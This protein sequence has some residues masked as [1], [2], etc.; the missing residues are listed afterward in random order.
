MPAPEPNVTSAPI[1]IVGPSR[2][3][4][5]M[6]REVFNR[7]PDVWITRETHYFDDLR[8]RRSASRDEIEDYFLRIGTR[9]YGAAFSA[10][11][12]DE[13]DRLRLRAAAAQLGTGRDAYFEAF[14]RL[15][16]AREG[17]A[18]WGEKTPRHVFRV[19]ELLAAYPE[20]RVI[21]M[22]RDP[23]AVVASYRDWTRR[24]ELSPDV[25]SPFAEDRQRARS[26]YG[27]L[28]SCL[29]CK[30][31]LAAG[32]RAAHRHGPDRVRVVAFEALAHAPRATL[33]ELCSWL[34]V[35]FD[36]GMLD[37]PIVQ[38]SYASRGARGI[39]TA[40]LERWRTRLSYQE[41]R[42]I[43]AACARVM[44]SLGYVRATEGWAGPA[45]LHSLALL[46]LDA[47]RAA[48]ANR[49][50]MGSPVSYVWKRL[51]LSVGWR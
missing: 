21:C 1:F 48:R 9:A 24:P 12:A 34:D 41:T 32:L 33:Q 29:M 30:S 45:L 2:S 13:N 40:P 6:L 17:R 44:R 47:V 7:H 51:S 19:D 31:A 18:R 10:D 14:C 27:L 3:G 46:P 11:E 15:C 22:A 20:A 50:R 39:S 38:S 36:E 28:L 43:E 16:A 8:R 5:S 26:S 23:R 4:T 25:D 49:G 37:V 35:T 42:T